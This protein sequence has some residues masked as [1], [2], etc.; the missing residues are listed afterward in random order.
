[1][2]DNYGTHYRGMAP[3]KGGETQIAAAEEITPHAKKMRERV[4]E[5]LFDA[6]D[7][8]TNHQISEVTGINLDTVKPRVRELRMEG[9]VKDTLTARSNFP[10]TKGMSKVWRVTRP[11]EQPDDIQPKHSKAY[12]QGKRDAFLE[13]KDFCDSMQECT[14]GW[15]ETSI[16]AGK[17]V[18]RKLIQLI[19]EGE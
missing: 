6:P 7:G 3:H 13:M 4:Y 15:W 1:M 16:H 10:Y 19:K 2:D 14:N 12:L 18:Y 17:D 11:D 8:M 5:A 9:K